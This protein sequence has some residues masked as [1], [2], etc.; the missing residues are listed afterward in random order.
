MDSLDS[1]NLRKDSDCLLE[2]SFDEGLSSV[3]LG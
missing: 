2:S 3:R 1:A